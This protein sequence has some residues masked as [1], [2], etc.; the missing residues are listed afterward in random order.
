M[1]CHQCSLD[2]DPTLFPIDRRRKSGRGV[3]CRACV[4]RVKRATRAA[5]P[6]KFSAQ[7]K[8]QR[9]AR[10]EEIRARERVLYA[11]NRIH[12]RARKNRNRAEN[13]EK[14]RERE[15]AWEAAR[16]VPR[17]AKLRRIYAEDPGTHL[18]RLERRRAKK[19]GLPATF[20][21]DDYIFMHQYWHFVCAI[22][23][24][25][26]GFHWTLALDHFIPMTAPNC[27][28]TVATNILPLCHGQGGCNNV[29]GSQNPQAWLLDRFGTR[30]AASILK[31]IN[32]YFEVVRQRA[33]PESAAAD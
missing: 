20:M 24:N 11:I 31:K 30:K 1:I 16:R 26:E 28:G 25:Q 5:N 13:L 9:L 21:R 4:N 6:E 2:K 27:P 22:C 29:K 17:L 33:S 14:V 3:T 10:L 32:A 19:R 18:T 8:A 23:G 15:R 12:I 7:Q